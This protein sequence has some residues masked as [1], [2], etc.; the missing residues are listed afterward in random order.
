MIPLVHSKVECSICHEK[1]HYAPMC[2]QRAERDARRADEEQKYATDRMG[3]LDNLLGRF[4]EEP[5]QY[6]SNGT[7][8]KSRP[9]QINSGS[10]QQDGPGENMTS[11][12]AGM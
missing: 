2:P 4:N 7:Q 10:R 6:G 9:H 3:R 8:S 11:G 1:G 12:A 5:N